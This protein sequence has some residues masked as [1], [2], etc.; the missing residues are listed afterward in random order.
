MPGAF[1]ATFPLVLAAVLVA[2]G[3]SKFR[4]PDDLTGW[5]SLGVPA[6]F[7][8]PWLL[9]LH[10]WG[11]IA[12]GVA[13]AVLGGWL[14]L[15]ASLSAVGLMIGYTVLVARAAGRAD[16]TSCACFGAQKRVTRM[17]VVR[18]VWLTLLAL[19][20][21]AVI[22]ATPLVGGALAIG[23]ADWTWLL[24]LA[25][26][27]VTVALILWPEADAPTAAENEAGVPV[28]TAVGDDGEYVRTRTPAVPVTLADGTVQ[29]L[30]VI[31]ARKPLLLLAVSPTCSSCRPVIEMV[32]T[33]R[34]L[35]P[36]LDVRFL[37][38]TAP[39][40]STL[41]ERDEPQSLHDP[42]GYVR[43]SIEDWPTPTAVLL[44]ADG[45]LAGG[46]VSGAEEIDVFFDDVY[47][48]LH[49]ERPA[50]S[51]AAELDSASGRWKTAR[52]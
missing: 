13:I 20:S 3:V 11:E 16:D 51:T 30:R 41:I 18:N 14:G 17:T 45:M 6:A 10:P 21:T 39:E 29:N 22:W 19:A 43:D 9:R 7:R 44:G 40:A 38:S 32:G 49:G 50:R 31:A 23:L 36:E 35:M 34:R 25:V 24:A 2:S 42:E 12:L 4:A 52:Q 1:L 5:E 46:P 28:D 15:L 27:A 48:S 47:E 37:L 8:R 26:A 33:Y